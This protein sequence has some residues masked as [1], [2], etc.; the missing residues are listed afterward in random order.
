MIPNLLPTT[1]LYALRDAGALRRRRIAL[2][3]VIA[4]LLVAL[5]SLQWSGLQNARFTTGYMLLGAVLF[6][7]SLHW[8]KQMP[9]LP[10][11]KVSHWL[12]YHIY[13]GYLTILLFGL[14]INFRPPTGI[15]DTALFAVFVI[16]VVG[17]LYGLY[18]TRTYPRQLRVLPEE[19]IYEQIPR[20]QREIVEQARNIVLSAAHDSSAL[21]DHYKTHLAPFLEQRRGIFYW[22]YPNSRRRRLLMDQ[23]RELPR[24][25]SEPRRQDCATLQKL[26]GRKD[27]LDFQ[28]ALQSRLKVWLFVHIGFSYSLLILGLVHGLVMHAFAGGIR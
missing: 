21:V 8:R 10:L 15:L 22:L 11:G 19:A 16:V 9:S 3:C 13:V 25:L 27:D 24:F 28:W 2:T 26:L 5:V 20:L 12:Q 18:I 23:L 1:K 4:A 17:G 6:L 14:H 7:I